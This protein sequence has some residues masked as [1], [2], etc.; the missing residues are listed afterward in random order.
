MY[1]YLKNIMNTIEQEL[2][3]AINYIEQNKSTEISISSIEE[4]L[5]LFYS[6]VHIQAL[7]KPCMVGDGIHGIKDLEIDEI[8]ALYNEAAK[9][10]R[11]I[12]FVPASGVASRMFHKL[13]SVLIRFNDF[14]L[15]DLKKYSKIAM[16]DVQPPYFKNQS[17]QADIVFDHHPIIMLFQK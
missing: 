2:K 16:V 14:T 4:Q 7:A 1:R 13:Q 11:L 10:G 12:K 6:G 8:L 5:K 17:I 3:K 15:D 9:A